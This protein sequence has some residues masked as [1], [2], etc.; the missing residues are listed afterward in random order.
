[1]LNLQTVNLEDKTIGEEGTHAEEFLLQEK[2]SE[3]RNVTV[4]MNNSP[5]STPNHTINCG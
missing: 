3:V 5:C 4:F 2:K 1:M